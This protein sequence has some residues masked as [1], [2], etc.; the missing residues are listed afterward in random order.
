MLQ[1]TNLTSNR[2]LKIRNFDE[3]KIAT[4]NA[5]PGLR[6]EGKIVDYYKFS[7]NYFLLDNVGELIESFEIAIL[8][9]KSYPNTFPIIALLDEKINRLDEYH[10]DEH[11]IVCIEHTYI[12][13]KLAKE[14][15]RIYDFVNYYL[16]KYFS[17][18][19]VKKS[20]V[21]VFLQEW[22]H[23]DEGTIQVYET[24]LEMSDKIQITYFLNNY[25]NVHKIGRNDKCYCGCGK[26]LKYCHY[27]AALFLKNISRKEIEKDIA[28]FK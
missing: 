15:L 9:H 13:N 25:L 4:L 14:G 12:A 5:H 11:G 17:W 16:P 20:G 27:I 19:L 21:A 24:L 10:V 7:G 23:H 22:A 1:I 2:K 8:V 28:L 3:D 6:Y 18:A 26:K